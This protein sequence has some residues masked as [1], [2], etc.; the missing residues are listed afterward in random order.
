LDSKIQSIAEDCAFSFKGLY[1]QSSIKENYSSFLVFVPII[2]SIT[3]LVFPE[4]TGTLAGRIFSVATL[5]F[6][7]LLLVVN[8]STEN[9]IR[10][11]EIANEYKKLYDSLYL[12]FGKGET[13]EAEVLAILSKKNE[14]NNLTSQYPIKFIAKTITRRTIRKEMSLDWIYRNT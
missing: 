8:K 3:V 11:R 9:V 10:Y 14:L 13:A 2:F 1:K 4:I 7:I 12:L 6:S 5:V